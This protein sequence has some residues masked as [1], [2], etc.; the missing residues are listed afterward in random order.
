MFGAILGDIIGSPYE[1]DSNN[2]KSK[3]FPLFSEKSKYTDDSVMTVAVADALLSLGSQPD[4]GLLEEAVIYS[5][6]K[7]GRR[8]PLA[9]YGTRFSLWLFSDD[10]SPYNSWGNGSAMRVSPVAWVFDSISSVRNAARI[11]AAVTHN[12]KEGIKG[13]EAAASAVFLARTGSS[14]SDI[15]DYIE[16]EFGYDLSRSC[17][18][19]RPDYRHDESCAGTVPEALTAFLEGNSFEDV[20]RTA[21]SLGGD[22]DTLTAIAAS[23][24]EAY[25]GID[26]R[27]KNE[28]LSRLPKDLAD[29]AR[30]FDIAYGVHLRYEISKVYEAVVFAERAHRGQLRKGS[31][32]A[33]ITHPMEVFQILTA[34]NANDDLLIAGLLHDTVEDTSVTL[35][36]IRLSFGER[37]AYLVGSHTEDKS[38][39]WDE[40]KAAAICELRHAERDI[41]LLMMADKVSNLRSMLSD[42]IRVGDKLWERF[43]AGKDKQARLNRDFIDALESMR[44]DRDA[45]PVYR[46]MKGLFRDLF[47]EFRFDRISGRLYQIPFGMGACELKDCGINGRK[48]MELSKTE[49]VP[50]SAQA[51]PRTLAER[52]EEL[53][54]QAVEKYSPL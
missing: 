4:M 2:I 40:R 47:V 39:S 21:V 51:I 14:K 15:K 28:A 34:M 29:T 53:H 19:I 37:A 1:F 30:R 9:G 33:Y 31:D 18:D 35:E 23:V 11:T 22:C 8:Y 27:L 45:G 48:W 54:R 26:S 13:A 32:T 5:M 12:H 50:E 44:F 16:Q 25:Y 6:R 24:A 17:D 46:E 10:P 20:I 38:K 49:R 41:R 42:Y 43:N 7:W 3:D 36:D 52:I